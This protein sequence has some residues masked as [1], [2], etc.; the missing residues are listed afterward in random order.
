MRIAIKATLLTAMLCT[1]FLSGCGLQSGLI[2]VADAF[3]A[4]AAAGDF[5]TAYQLTSS[6]FRKS[7]SVEKMQEFLEGRALT[8]YESSDWSSWELTTEQ[9]TLEGTITTTDGSSIPVT[10]VFVKKGEEW[11]IHFID[12]GSAGV[13]EETTA[14]PSLP[15]DEVLKLLTDEAIQQLASAINAADFT[16]LHSYIAQLWQSQATADDLQ[17]YFQEFIDEQVDLSVLVDLEPV[18]SEPP[19][20]DEDGVLILKGYYASQPATTHYELS[21]SYEHP[22]WKLIGIDV[23]T[24]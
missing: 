5:A 7:I 10:V 1:I 21:Y 15:D 16:G 8:E 12:A 9:G 6:G 18:F 2:E 17:G 4:A 24:R 3:F 22:D 20:I 23:E 13:S 11:R 19:A 14:S